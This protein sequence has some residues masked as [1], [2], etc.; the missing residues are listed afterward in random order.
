MYVSHQPLPHGI[1][2]KHDIRYSGTSLTLKQID[3][4]LRVHEARHHEQP[5][6]PHALQPHQTTNRRQRSR[7]PC[8]KKP[9]RQTQSR[10][11]RVQTEVKIEDNTGNNTTARDSPMTRSSQT[12]TNPD[13]SQES[14]SMTPTIGPNTEP[15]T[16]QT[17]NIPPSP[18]HHPDP[19]A[20]D[21]GKLMPMS[22]SRTSTAD[23]TAFRLIRDRGEYILYLSRAWLM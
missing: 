21:N 3:W 14:A 20:A 8:I 10:K 11:K 13:A 15:T 17:F 5:R 9:Q 19:H 1:S 4:S 22:H 12:F 16:C 6:P 7:P 18:L 23:R 2:L